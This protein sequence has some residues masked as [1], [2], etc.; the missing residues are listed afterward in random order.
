MIIESYF[1]L[2]NFWQ[3]SL[4]D[5]TSRG[6]TAW[7]SHDT[8]NCRNVHDLHSSAR[9]RHRRRVSVSVNNLHFL[10]LSVFCCLGY[11]V[12]R[13][14]ACKRFCTLSSGN[15]SFEM[16]REKLLFKLVVVFCKLINGYLSAVNVL[17]TKTRFSLMFL[18]KTAVSDNWHYCVRSD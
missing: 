9:T 10:F 13:S 16:R 14:N 15:T 3:Q 5:V 4:G 7:S 11:F 8:G 2:R 12:I 6:A 17:T 18:S 1:S